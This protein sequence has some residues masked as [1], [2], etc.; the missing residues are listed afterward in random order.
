MTRRNA[1]RRR[2]SGRAYSPDDPENR[3]GTP[4]TFRARRIGVGV[5][6]RADEHRVVARVGTARDP[7]ARCRPRSSRLPPIPSRTPRAGPAAAPASRRSGP[8]P[9]DDAGPHLEP[10]GVVEADEPIRRVEDRARASGSC[11]AGRRSGR[12]GSAPRSRGCCRSRRRG[13]RRSPGRRR[14]RP[15]RSRCGSAS[16]RDELRLRAVRVLE[17]VDQEVSEALSDRLPGGRGAAHEP[18]GQRDLVAEVDEPVA[19]RAA[20]GSARTR[21]RARPVGGLPRRAPPHRRP[22]RPRRRPLRRG[23]SPRPPVA[24]RGPT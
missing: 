19:R 6:V 4:A 9:L 2:T 16:S 23:R 22:Q 10:V 8:Q 3:H 1:I 13:T 5:A 24:R 12:P 21:G 7:C 18:E 11:G 15:S 14:R 20:P 17:L